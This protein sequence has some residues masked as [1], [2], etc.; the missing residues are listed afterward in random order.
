[1]TAVT[2]PSRIVVFAKAPVPGRV[3]TRL[4]SALGAEG[5]ARLAAALLEA[6]LR[7]ARASGLAVELCGDPDPQCWWRTDAGIALTAQNQGDLGARLAAA[8][9]RVLS[10]GQPVLLIG[11]DCP[12]V[13]ARRL[14][15][16]ARAL[17]THDAVIHPAKD[18]GYALLGLRRFDSTLFEAIDWSGPE[19]A[20][21]TL[22][23]IAAL[24]WSVW[25]GET[26][27][28]VDEP[29]DLAAL[30]GELVQFLGDDAAPLLRP[31]AA[32]SGAR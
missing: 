5:A 18:G 24:G 19:V 22:A 30:E 9:A 1:M 3:K 32:A 26:M 20:G 31:A 23:R 11:A 25:I 28:D 4:V 6:T 29:E 2:A 15:A 8:A 17:D 21:Q 12:A 7:E 10:G 16:A 14:A 27:R 13:D